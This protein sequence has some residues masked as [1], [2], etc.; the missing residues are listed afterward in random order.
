MNI[1]QNNKKNKGGIKKLLTSNIT[2]MRKNLFYTVMMMAVVAVVAMTFIAC[3]GDN[4]E[5]GTNYS[6][7]GTWQITEMP[8]GESDL[9]VGDLIFITADGKIYDEID[10]IGTWG[11]GGQCYLT[12]SESYPVPFT[13]KVLSLTENYMSIDITIYSI[14]FNMKFKRVNTQS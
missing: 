5:P 7:V 6:V 8:E 12:D 3:G 4:D 13:A 14:T 1:I 2:I 10:E 11:K 9:K